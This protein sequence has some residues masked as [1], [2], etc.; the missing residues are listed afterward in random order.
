MAECNHTTL[1]LLPP[2]GRALRCRRCHL[3]LNADEAADGCPECFE[4]S[5]RRHREF[6]EFT[7][8]SDS[9]VAYRCESCGV[10][11]KCR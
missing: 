6:D 2:R 8:S 9:A 10:L 1:E 3:T 7:P 11:V 4:R 5:G